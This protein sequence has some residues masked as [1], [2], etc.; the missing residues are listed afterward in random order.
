MPKAKKTS[1]KIRSTAQCPIEL[2]NDAVS[3][4]TEAQSGEG[5]WLHKK[6]YAYL[7]FEAPL[8]VWG[9]SR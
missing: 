7:D 2:P 5:R 9:S 1:S 4:T 6:N 8:G 3:D